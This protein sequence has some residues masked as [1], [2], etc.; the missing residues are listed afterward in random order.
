MSKINLTNDEYGYHTKSLKCKYHTQ[1]KEQ[2]KWLCTT[3]QRKKRL[4]D[5]KKLM[6]ET[7]GLSENE[8]EYRIKQFKNLSVSPI[9]VT[10]RF[11]LSELPSLLEVLEELEDGSSTFVIDE[12]GKF[13]Y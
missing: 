1:V 7:F 13:R 2:L 10:E 11:Y 12:D 8:T 4:E 5:G 6:A 9:S 3:M